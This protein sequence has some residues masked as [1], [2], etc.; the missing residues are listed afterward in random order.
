[1]SGL[2]QEPECLRAVG[3]HLLILLSILLY[4]LFS[5]LFRLQE[6]GN[7]VEGQIHA[8]EDLLSNI[9]AVHG[10]GKS[11][12]H[13]RIGECFIFAIKAYSEYIR[14]ILLSVEGL[15]RRLRHKSW[16]FLRRYRC[17]GIDLL[18]QEIRVF[19]I[20]V[21]A[22]DPVY[23]LIALRRIS[24]SVS[25]V[26]PCGQLSLVRFTASVVGIFLQDIF[27][28]GNDGFDHVG[29]V[30]GN[31]GPVIDITVILIPLCQFTQGKEGPGRTDP[32][33]IGI[34]TREFYDKSAVIRSG[35]FQRAG[36]SPHYFRVTGYILCQVLPVKGFRG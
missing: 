10:C 36:I 29:T 19:R 8:V 33:K 34:R 15:Q 24:R 28:S 27:L 5:L 6:G 26:Q 30:S 17:D 16:F 3:Q 12:A 1:M 25:G 2:L 23:G 4:V 35:N 31:F 9:G 18:V 11:A 22:D 13:A 21:S 14:Y 20:L 7:T 32:G